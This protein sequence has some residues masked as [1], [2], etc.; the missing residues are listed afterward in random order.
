MRKAFLFLLLFASVYTRAQNLV[1]NPSFETKVSCPDNFN[2]LEL[3][4][5]WF[6]ASTGTPDYFN[7]CFFDNTH[8]WNG[9]DVPQN[10][11][12][13]QNAKSGNA[14]VGLIVYSL[15]Y[16]N[17][18]EYIECKLNSPLQ[19]GLK[20]YVSFFTSLS[21][22]SNQSSSDLGISFSVDSINLNS[23]TDISTIPKI[24]N[25][26]NNFI[27]DKNNWTKIS[28]SFIA[29]SAYQY[30]LIGN[31]K[32]D[33]NID[34][35]SVFG[36][37]FINYY[38]DTYYYLDDVCVSSDSSA[39]DFG[40]GIKSI[41]SSFNISPNPATDKIYFSLNTNESYSYSLLNLLGEEIKNSTSSGAAALD[42]ADV[43]A[44][45]YILRITYAGKTI[46]RKQVILHY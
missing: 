25:S 22:S 15:G 19:K 32:D 11:E 30:I 40:E 44:G 14:Y 7:S 4:Q 31:F 37:G 6:S 5:H 20:Y 18:R 1:P 39:C 26:Q 43:P 24:V 12:G 35:I 13:Y 41:S 45:I 16:Y 9:M 34:T 21:D 27:T 2:Q 3:A 10:V 38:F 42:M 33:L 8:T 29:D 46:Q 28:R 36:G 23:D 17:Y